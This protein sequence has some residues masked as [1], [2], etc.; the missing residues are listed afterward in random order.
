MISLKLL[1]CNII[2]FSSSYRL[3]VIGHHPLTL[4]IC[5]V[6][7]NRGWEVFINDYNKNGYWRD[8]ICE[9]DVIDGIVSWAGEQCDAVI[10]VK[11][12]SLPQD[13]PDIYQL[14]GSPTPIVILSIDR[15]PIMDEWLSVGKQRLVHIIY[16]SDT[17]YITTNYIQML[18][19]LC[20][21]FE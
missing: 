19:N 16:N 8:Q 15:T 7:S 11:S 4:D 3:G 21:Y 17:E 13:P 10:V 5:R 1:L 12:R 9:N 18:L 20:D 2:C 6:A 14:M